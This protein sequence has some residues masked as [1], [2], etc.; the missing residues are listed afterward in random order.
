MNGSYNRKEPLTR[1]ELPNGPWIEIAVDFVGP[2]DHD[3]VFVFM[4]VDLYS[5]YLEAIVMRSI[6][7]EKVI[8]QLKML[9]GRF[10]YPRTITADNGSQ[11][12]SDSFKRFVTE[13]GSNL[14]LVAPYSAWQ[15]GTVERQNRD[16][17][18]FIRRTKASKKDWKEELPD[19]LLEK[20]TSINSTTNKTPA[21]L[22]FGRILRNKIPD[23][24]L[25]YDENDEDVRDQDALM[26]Q[27]GKEYA[28]KHRHA[29]DSN[30]NLGDTVVAQRMQKASKLDSNYIPEKHTIVEEQGKEVILRNEDT[31]SLQRRNKV[32]V[33]QIPDDVSMSLD[34]PV[35]EEAV[36]PKR[37]I[38]KPFKF[39]DFMDWD[40]IE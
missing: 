25:I 4:V 26:K 14:N 19:Y 30:I 27:K 2:I 5:R 3:N 32:H 39:T 15:N 28:D 40:S 6:T 36:R 8:K 7:A 17:K 33:K 9:F 34:E 20:H 16:F 11:F 10:G 13:I 22:F 29:I 23:I 35:I 18:E 24:S 31:G 21:E 38:Q 12:I 1:K 37:N